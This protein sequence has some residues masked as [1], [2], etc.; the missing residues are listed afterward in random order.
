MSVAGRGSDITRITIMTHVARNDRQQPS[1]QV[2]N[3][4]YPLVRRRGE[5]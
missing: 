5:V 3:G 4:K 2:E 1:N